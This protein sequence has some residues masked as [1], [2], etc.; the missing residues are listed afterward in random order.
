[1]GKEVEDVVVNDK[2]KSLVKRVKEIFDAKFSVFDLPNNQNP[3]HKLRL[4][5]K[6]YLTKK[7]LPQYSISETLN[8]VMNKVESYGQNSQ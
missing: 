7:Y 4:A 2:C 1:M 6:I 5:I 8:K 3:C